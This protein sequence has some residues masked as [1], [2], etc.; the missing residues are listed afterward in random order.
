MNHFP[1]VLALLLASTSYPSAWAAPST[2]IGKVVIL[3]GKAWKVAGKG[4]KDTPLAVGSELHDHDR[5]RT[6]ADSRVTILLGHDVAALL[7]PKSDATIDQVNGKDW[8]IRM[9]DGSILSKVV[10][11]EMRPDHF[12]IKTRSATMGVRGTLFFVKAVPTEPVFL[13]TCNGKIAVSDAQGHTHVE[14]SGTHHDAPKTIRD[15]DG[16]IDGR[17]DA[18]PQGTDHTDEDGAGLEKLL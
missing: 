15:G 8:A 3:Q 1:L 16:K 5:I 4:K 12:K 7:N 18:A 2:V 11:P 9:K 17:L 14:V 13:C 10:N 6:D